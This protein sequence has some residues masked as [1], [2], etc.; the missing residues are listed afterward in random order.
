MRSGPRGNEYCDNWERDS[1]AYECSICGAYTNVIKVRMNRTKWNWEDPWG[2]WYYISHRIYCPN[3]GFQ[4]HSEMSE[5]LQYL[6]EKPHPRSIRDEIISEILEMRKANKVED[7][8][9]GK[10]SGEKVLIDPVSKYDENQLIKS[11]NWKIVAPLLRRM[12]SQ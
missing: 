11:R 4:W 6:L 7:D 5:K 10:I 3:E 9:T 1:H 2:P 12:V 8:V